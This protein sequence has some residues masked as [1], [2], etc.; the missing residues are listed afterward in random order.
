MDTLSQ[1]LR[2]QVVSWF[3]VGLESHLILGYPIHTP[4]DVFYGI[5]TLLFLSNSPSDMVVPESLDE[6]LIV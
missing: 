1:H 3:L 4:A 5:P 6:R 2:D